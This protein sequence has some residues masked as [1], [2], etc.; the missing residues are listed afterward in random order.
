M[1]SYPCPILFP[2]TGLSSHIGGDTLSLPL[3]IYSLCFLC[4]ECS[5][6]RP[7]HAITLICAQMSPLR[8]AALGTPIQKEEAAILGQYPCPTLG[9]PWLLLIACY[10]LAHPILL[11][12]G[13][14]GTGTPP[15]LFISASPMATAVPG[16][17]GC[18]VNIC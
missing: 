14:Q 5:P 11:L 7:W 8:E 9:P 4:L 1:G 3:A 18:S 10:C 13:A 17:K 15:V 16:M 12:I 2:T 6:F